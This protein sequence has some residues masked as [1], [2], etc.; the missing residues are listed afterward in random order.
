MIR[1]AI[2]EDDALFQSKIQRYLS[3]FEEQNAQRFSVRVFDSGSE[4]LIDYHPDYDIIFMDIE[5]PGLNGMETAKAI[6][7]LD[8]HTA[9]AFITNMAN[10]AIQGYEVE[11]IDFIVKPFTYEVFE[12][13]LSRILS[14]TAFRREENYVMI[15]AGD[16]TQKLSISE[17]L[18]VEVSHHTLVYHTQKEA[19][20][21][22]GSMREAQQELEKYGFCKCS[23][24]FLV[25]LRYVTRIEPEEAYL[26]DTPIHISRGSKKELIRAMSEFMARS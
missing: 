22:R 18:Y 25:N 20:S 17:I 3:R 9:I 7:R 6:R 5:M 23:Q 19:I 26:G 11:A 10:Y 21:V 24:S 8:T 1:I 2:V 15:N 12:F 14:R 13:K 16:M 4:F